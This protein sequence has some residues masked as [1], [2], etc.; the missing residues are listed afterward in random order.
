MVQV[1]PPGPLP[2]HHRRPAPAVRAREDPARRLAGRVHHG[3]D[4]RAPCPRSSGHARTSTGRSPEP[5]LRRSPDERRRSA[6]QRSFRC[7]RHCKPRS[8]GRAARKLARQRGRPD[9]LSDIDLHSCAKFSERVHRRQV[10]GPNLGGGGGRR[11]GNILPEYRSLRLGPLAR[12]LSVKADAT[13][14]GVAPPPQR[15]PLVH[16]A[17]RGD[18]VYSYGFHGFVPKGIASICSG[19]L[20]TTPVGRD[21]GI[22]AGTEIWRVE[23][24][25]GRFGDLSRTPRYSRLPVVDGLHGHAT[26]CPANVA[27]AH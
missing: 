15:D 18:A 4:E 2:A 16:I 13:R 10:H 1:P 3:A 5:H 12:S 27:T 25:W 21:V 8:D 24:E 14:V 7:V 6:R 9:S 26:D 11:A 22:M 17:L 19:F 20:P 23:F